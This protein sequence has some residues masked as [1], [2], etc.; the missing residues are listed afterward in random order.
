[1]TGGINID[2]KNLSFPNVV[3]Q[4]RGGKKT[5]G[6][7]FKATITV[8]FSSKSNISSM[9]NKLN[10]NKVNVNQSS[11]NKRDASFITSLA[12]KENKSEIIQ[13]NTKNTEPTNATA[14]IKPT[15]TST[16]TSG[17]NGINGNN[18]Q[19][20]NK[21][22]GPYDNTNQQPLNTSISTG[23]AS[24]NIQNS[25]DL[26][27]KMIDN[28]NVNIDT[29]RNE[30]LWIANNIQGAVFLI[31]SN[32]GTASIDDDQKADLMQI[33]TNL[34]RLSPLLEKLIKPESTLLDEKS[35]STLRAISKDENGSLQSMANL[36]QNILNTPG[37]NE[38]LD[39][40]KLLS[41]N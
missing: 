5:I 6:S 27:K 7:F 39:L 24:N 11:I 26:I 15:N 32:G 20:P 21:V 37:V 10:T 16:N 28:Q 4:L 3:K 22:C 1:M 30:I 31:K 2:N 8:L 41:S 19:E 38:L 9:I 17:I 35:K 36:L 29:L 14:N 34:I 13:K 12:F 25:T 33:Q 40:F 18:Y 23:K